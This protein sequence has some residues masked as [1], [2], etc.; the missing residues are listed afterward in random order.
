MLVLLLLIIHSRSEHSSLASSSRLHPF[1][2]CPLARLPACPLARVL[3]LSLSL[4]LSTVLHYSSLSPSLSPSSRCDRRVFTTL[5]N[6]SRILV[7]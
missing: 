3:S 7:M 5:S 2:S 6:S 1:C 4:S